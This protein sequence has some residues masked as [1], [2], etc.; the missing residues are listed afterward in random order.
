MMIDVPQIAGWIGMILLLVA[1]GGR[2]KLSPRMYALLNLA[3]AVG[4]IALTF[5]QAA[6]P[7][8]AL[9]VV[10]AAIA[11]RDLWQASGPRSEGGVTPADCATRD[12]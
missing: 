6:W 4:L 3:G 10:W 1:Y 12:R 2:Q 7:A 9:E 11:A 8:C 5:V